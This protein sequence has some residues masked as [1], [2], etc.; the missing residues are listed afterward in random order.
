VSRD[1]D[2]RWTVTPFFRIVADDMNSPVADRRFPSIW[3][4][5]VSET[6]CF[7]IS[8]LNNNGGVQGNS[9]ISMTVNKV[10]EGFR[11]LEEPRLPFKRW[12]ECEYVNEE[13]KPA[14][15]VLFADEKEVLELN[16]VPGTM[17]F[18]CYSLGDGMA[19][20]VVYSIVGLVNSRHTVSN[21][22]KSSY[23][24]QRKLKRRLKPGQYPYLGYTEV[25]IKPGEAIELIPPVSGRG[26]YEQLNHPVMGH[27]HWYRARNGVVRDGKQGLWVHNWINDYRKGNPEKGMIEHRY[28]VVAE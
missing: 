3:H 11:F 21:D 20:P 5:L 25:K 10:K 15:V 17:E 19:T 4:G 22:K 9:S 24:D 26:G 2:R 6:H 7:D 1:N 28:K 16:L 23:T 13:L 14:Y 8:P 18:H 27:W 12:F